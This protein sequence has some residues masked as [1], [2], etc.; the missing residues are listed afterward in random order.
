[1]LGSNLAYRKTIARRP[2]ISAFGKQRNLAPA[3]SGEPAEPTQ[4][5]LTIQN[6]MR[7]FQF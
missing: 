1:M 3:I 2:Q 6:E 4:G 5:P 7:A